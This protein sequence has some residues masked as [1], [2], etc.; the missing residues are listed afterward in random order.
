MINKKINF[1]DL[2]KLWKDP[3]YTQQ[4]TKI[5]V[6]QQDFICNFN[7]SD[8]LNI[9]LSMITGIKCLEKIG[10]IDVQS[11]NGSELKIIPNTGT[12][13]ISEI[14]CEQLLI[15]SSVQD[16][17]FKNDF[18]ETDYC[19]ISGS[20][21]IYVNIL[22]LS[23]TS[24]LYMQNVSGTIS[25]II[26]DSPSYIS[27]VDQA[28]NIEYFRN[29]QGVPKNLPFNISGCRF[30]NSNLLLQNIP[31]SSGYYLF[32]YS[33]SIIDTLFKKSVIKYENGGISFINSLDSSYAGYFSDTSVNAKTVSLVATVETENL[34][35]GQEPIPLYGGY[36]SGFQLNNADDVYIYNYKQPYGQIQTLYLMI[37]N[38]EYLDSTLELSVASG[39]EFIPRKVTNEHNSPTHGTSVEETVIEGTTYYENTFYTGVPVD[40]Y[41]SCP[42]VSIYGKQDIYYQLDEHPDETIIGH[43]NY[44]LLMK[45]I[46]TNKLNI[47]N[48]AN[49]GTLTVSRRAEILRGINFGTIKL[50]NTGVHFID[51]RFKNL[52]TIEFY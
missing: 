11:N 1:C 8:F 13:E 15:N 22:S 50:A 49:Y 31:D 45:D 42:N 21:N 43:Y 41:I 14:K 2:N 17:Y 20:N 35:G 23:S 40:L 19:S 46:Q 51:P 9:E 39:L 25:E 37:N 47:D 27:G 32:K 12:N 36:G 30:E 52:G 5:A 33:P 34:P 44:A 4:A 28:A 38:F 18:I 48:F 16:P 26:C 7:A 6:E 24:G 3:Y 10:S 29:T